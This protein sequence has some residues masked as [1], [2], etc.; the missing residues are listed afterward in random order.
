MRK[1]TVAELCEALSIWFPASKAQPDVELA[2][3]LLSYKAHL[4][5]EN[6]LLW[7]PR[8]VEWLL[9]HTLPAEGLLTGGDA[10]AGPPRRGQG[11]RRHG[12]PAPRSPQGSFQGAVPTLSLPVRRSGAP[13]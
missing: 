13:S 12:R 6:P 2:S 10:P 5:K 8:D 3:L 9:L 7:R 1:E 4:R 11:D